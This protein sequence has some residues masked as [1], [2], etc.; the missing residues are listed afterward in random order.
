[1]DRT[2][3]YNTYQMTMKYTSNKGCLRKN[4]PSRERKT[5][6]GFIQGPLGGKKE[7]RFWASRVREVFGVP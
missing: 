7:I 4:D 5:L 3:G 2:K 6:N 1:M